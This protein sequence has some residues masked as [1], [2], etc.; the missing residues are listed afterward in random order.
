MNNVHIVTA[1]WGSDLR[2]MSQA[3]QELGFSFS[4]WT[5]HDL[6][7]DDSTRDSFLAACRG[8]DIVLLHPSHDA[9][10]DEVMPEIPGDIPIATFGYGQG[11][12]AGATVPLRIVSRV[13]LYALY[14]GYANLRNMLAYLAA[15]VLDEDIA[16]DPPHE[17]RWEGIYHPE[18]ATVFD[19]ID[20]YLS[21]YSRSAPYQIGIIF[22]RSQW[23][24]GDTATVD[25]LIRGI[26]EF[27][28]VIPVFCFGVA[29]D[30]IGSRSSIDVIRDFLSDRIDLLVELR[31]FIHTRDT[32][33]YTGALR[34]LAVP[35]IHPLILYH[36]TL[37]DWQADAAGMSST[38]QT[39]CVALPEFQGM[40][41]MVLAGV[42]ERNKTEGYASERHVP[43][44]ER[45]SRIC[46]RIQKWLSLRARPVE[47]KKVA[48]IL[49][50][51]PCASVEATVGAGAGL[52]T[53]ESVARIL[54]AM[55][56]RG[57]EVHGP[58][59][60]DALITDIM[61]RK[62]ISEFRWTS[63][64]EIVDRG[65]SL[66]LLDCQTYIQWFEQFPGDVRD[67]IREAWGEPP[68]E[69][70]D[71]IPAAMVYDGRIVITGVEYGNA[72]VC[73]QPKRG[74]AGARCDG[75]VCRILHD[76]DVPPTHQYLATYR[77]LEDVWGAD[78]IVHVGTHGNLEFLP[79]KRAALSAGC[80]PDIAIGNV[81]H[82]YI[83]NADN[84]PE[85]TTAKR[86]SNAVLVDHAQAVMTES[87][88]YAG[89]RELDDQIGAWRRAREQDRARAHALEH[90]IIDLIEDADLADEVGL[91]RMRNGERSFE[92]IVTA[93]HEVLMRTYNTQIPAGMHIFGRMPEGAERVEFIAAAL[94]YDGGLRRAARRLLSIPE[95][96]ESADS[97][98]KV[99][100][101]AK[102]LV[103]GILAGENSDII[104][105]SPAGESTGQPRPS[106]ME[107]NA[108]ERASLKQISE[109]VRDLSD[110]I[111]RSE[112][113]GSLLQGM[114]GDFIP[115][116]PSGLVT[117][118]HPE[119]LPTGRN[120]YSLDPTRVPTRA[121]WRIG[122]RLAE[123]LLDRYRTESGS[124]PEHVAMYWMASDIMWADGE[125]FAQILSLIGAE[126]V[127]KE[128]R[129]RSFRII[130]LEEL[131]RPRI[132]VTIRTSGIL[133]DNFY[134][135]IELLDD[136]I[137]EVAALDEPEEMNFLR[138]HSAESG[139]D[140]I[141]GARPGTYGNG[142]SLAVY[143]SAWKEEEDLS[144]VFIHWN[145]YAYGR[146]RYGEENRELLRDQLSSVELTFNKTVTDEY[147]LLGCC[148][149][150]GVHG[151]LTSAVRSASGRQVPSYYGDT[152]SAER[153][154]VRS[155]ADE[156]R[157]VVRTRLLN[158]KWIE[159]MKRHGYKGAG[160][161]SRRVGTVYGWEATTQEVDDWIFDDIART[162]FLDEEM[163][164]F[165]GDHNPWALEEIGRRLMEAHARDLWD[166][167]P[168]VLDALKQ[169]YL[170]VEGWMEDRMEGTEGVQGGAVTVYTRDE[171]SAWRRAWER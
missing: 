3:A 118:G 24:N 168:D 81:P 9:F 67:A 115:P 50:N 110:R 152:R 104:S 66:A 158:P 133:R 123:G 40:I 62:A 141:F 132:N 134:N 56:Q 87:D 121:A 145:G 18:S 116:G 31:S 97:L 129:V 79:G 135:C 161:I 153:V 89:L 1:A 165:F 58:A 74:C 125:Q 96:E 76:P 41:D 37:E 2:L 88:L 8:A 53:L 136:A 99:D 83:Y 22:S 139:G 7:T 52:D 124:L 147:D 48:F 19:S 72:V 103:S 75:Q 33:A 10:W 71:G 95:D 30:E 54:H 65:G 151:G 70:R 23:V 92:E 44:E 29:D 159:G 171:V 42:A 55:E 46:A 68:G 91:G 12:W 146:D 138:K 36:T 43:V 137:Q 162:F 122:T 57:Y 38:E 80:Y 25:A 6:R 51:K 61:D 156:I 143:A 90:V 112:E 20:D 14:G 59:N 131:G 32:D 73:V 35:V 98:R 113:I 11:H 26:E 94:R 77:W 28:G 109:Q 17:T 130:P 82:L 21:W 167:D 117:R 157:R 127:W 4:A 34:D 169:A 101:A 166:A 120:F 170:E 5:V 93:A 154:E 106:A 108:M 15:E 27:A 45:V 102:E 144:D 39:W 100:N 16:Y 119:V 78:V 105:V 149:Y 126:P 69:E 84:P 85:G 142:V 128:G 148:C 49:H 150:F 107:L 86:R 60:G 164:T 155:L 163:R 111:D 160:D 140:H 114:D 63:V 13:S 47:K 64:Q